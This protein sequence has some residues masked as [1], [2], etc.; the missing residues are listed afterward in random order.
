MATSRVSLLTVGQGQRWPEGE[1]GQILLLSQVIAVNSD[2]RWQRLNPLAY[3]V[4]PTDCINHL[5][6]RD[7]YK[8]GVVNDTSWVQGQGFS[9][10]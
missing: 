10:R 7:N 6:G 4:R 9:A 5:S 2:S 8:I 3:H 1:L